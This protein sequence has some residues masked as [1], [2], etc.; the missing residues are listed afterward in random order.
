MDESLKRENARLR[1]EVSRL[2]SKIQILQADLQD[3]RIG[4]WKIAHH[5][6]AH[7]DFPHEV[8]SMQTFAKAVLPL[9]WHSS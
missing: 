5:K 3:A 7:S 1:K 6:P 2:I 4:L 8:G 9:R